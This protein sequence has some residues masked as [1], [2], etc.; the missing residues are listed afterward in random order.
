MKKGTNTVLGITS[1]A[2][3]VLNGLGL[4]GFSGALVFQRRVFM[5]IFMDFGVTLPLPTRLVLMIP[6]GLIIVITLVLLVLLIGKEFIGNK[7][8]PL[9]LNLVWMVAALGVSLLV[10]WALMAPVAGTIGE[11]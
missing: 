2:L 9:V 4:L 1:I 8:I 3:A 11:M 5:E 10:T 6:G 7:V